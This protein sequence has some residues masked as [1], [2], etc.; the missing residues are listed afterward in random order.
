MRLRRSR[1]RN[2]VSRHDTPTT[3]ERHLDATTACTG[4]HKESGGPQFNRF[5]GEKTPMTHTDVSNDV[6]EMSTDVGERVRK[7]ERIKENTNIIKKG[8]RRLGN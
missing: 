5:T 8:Q 3:I 2:P 4:T 6:E 1:A 7:T